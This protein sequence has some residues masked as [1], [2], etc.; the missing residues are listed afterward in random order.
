MDTTRVRLQPH[1]SQV[2]VARRQVAAACKGMPRDLVEIA[3]LLVSEMVTNA[4]RHG[5]G[6]IRLAVRHLPQ[7]LC[8]EVSDAG[9]GRPT[10]QD[11]RPEQANG[12]G[13]LL[14]ERLAQDWGVT[15]LAGG[16]KTVWF[17][18]RVA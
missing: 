6:G 8:V 2:S 17:T 10:T 7:R 12:R 1:E 18:L 15:R 11:P 9:A 13:L 3:V 4:I 14:V 16:G 5:R